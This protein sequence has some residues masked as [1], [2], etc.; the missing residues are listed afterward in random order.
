VILREWREAERELQ[1]GRHDP[2]LET[3]IRALRD[4]YGR[5]LERAGTFEDPVSPGI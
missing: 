4:E 5:A 2:H 1:A 3:R